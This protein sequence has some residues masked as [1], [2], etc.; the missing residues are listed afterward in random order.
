MPIDIELER[1]HAIVL[2]GS[3]GAGKTTLL[4]VLAG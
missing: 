1:G 4:R 3:N 2:T